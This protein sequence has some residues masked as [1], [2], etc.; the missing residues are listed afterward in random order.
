ME[1]FLYDLL[2]CYLVDEC[3]RNRGQEQNDTFGRFLRVRFQKLTLKTAANKALIRQT[4][5]SY[6]KP[7]PDENDEDDEGLFL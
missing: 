4:L 6:V 2:F 7:L 5:P 3:S 1:T